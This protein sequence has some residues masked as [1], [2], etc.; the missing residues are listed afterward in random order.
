[1][2]TEIDNV[3]ASI[4]KPVSDVL[5]NENFSKAS[6]SARFGD[7][8]DLIHIATHANFSGE[9]D[10]TFVL[11]YEDKLFPGDLEKSVRRLA[12]RKR[13]LELLVLSACETAVGDDR[14]ALGLAGIAVKSGAHSAVASL[15]AVDD[16]ATNV[17]ITS[18]YGNLFQEDSGDGKSASKAEC[19]RQAQLKVMRTPAW[20]HPQ[21]WAAFTV[22]GNWLSSEERAEIHSTLRQR[23][24]AEADR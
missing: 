17:L 2:A 10:E 19:L 8:F 4:G 6:F 23:K 18:F 5:M 3:S 7:D 20:S 21:Y 14:A 9:L 11:T 22:I 12:F 15:W 16:A 24:L 13:P 1:V